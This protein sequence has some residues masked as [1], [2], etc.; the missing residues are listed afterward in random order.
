MTEEEIRRLNEALAEI[1]TKLNAQ[2]E[3]AQTEISEHQRLSAETRT[4][5][6]KLLAEQGELVGRL[7]S[8]EQLLA[9]LNASGLG[10]GGRQPTMGQEFVENEQL[11]AW[12]QNPHGSIRL[13]VRADITHTASPDL[14]RG[15]RVPGIVGPAERRLTIADLLSWGPTSQSSVEFVRELVYTDNADVV[16]ENPASGKPQSEITF[17]AASAVVATIA[18]FVQAS[19]QVLADVPMLQSYIDG[20]LRYGYGLALEAQLL[21]GSG[22]GLNISGLYTQATAYS[23]PGVYVEAETRI[24]RLRLAML[25]VALSEYMSDAIVLNPIDWAWIEM[26]K[27]TQERYLFANPHNAT[28]PVL[29][30]INV[31]PTQSMSLGDFLTGSF[32]MGAQGWSREQMNVQISLEDQD[33]FIK[34]MATIRC[35]GRAALTV[36]RPAA[37]VK[38]NFD[39]LASSS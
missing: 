35:E 23:N 38:G 13:P 26:L 18:H 6:D 11:Q 12:V 5:V 16:S 39:D 25:Q 30:G 34:N 9:T 19:K 10:G 21:L 17:E 27:D 20:R 8:A 1:R 7:Q 37:F 36:Y 28:T 15:M 4:T 31:V 32:R 33:N 14:D 22:A 3:R 29:W 2:T 24:D